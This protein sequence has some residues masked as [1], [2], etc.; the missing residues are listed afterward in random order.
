MA[1]SDFTLESAMRD[2]GLNEVRADLFAGVKPVPMSGWLRETLRRTRDLGIL[3]ASEKARSEFLVAPILTELAESNAPNVALYSGKRLDA[4]PEQGLSGE[5]DFIIS[6]GALQRTIQTPIL[7]LVEAK[8]NDIELGLGQCIAQMAGARIYNEERDQSFAQIFGCVTTG[9]NWQFMCLSEV[10]VTFD[11]QV[12]YLDQ[13][14]DILG[15]LQYIV[16]SYREPSEGIK[17]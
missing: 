9:E 12:R 17:P 1:Y 13:V 8:K 15:I 14:E 11:L 4:K 3:S 10:L 16:D 5:C 2:L 7:A 6:R